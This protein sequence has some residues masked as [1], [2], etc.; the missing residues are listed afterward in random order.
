[1]VDLNCIEGI[2]TFNIKL[3]LFRI[4]TDKKTL[5]S[6]N[7]RKPIRTFCTKK[8]KIKLGI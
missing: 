4:Y 8:T 1:M 5:Y 6:R 7:Y 2:T 3:Q